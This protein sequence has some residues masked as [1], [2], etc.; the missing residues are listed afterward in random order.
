[1]VLRIRGSRLVGGLGNTVKE[2]VS[3]ESLYRRETVC[4]KERKRKERKGREGI[5]IV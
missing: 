4:G 2:T 1:M 5:S 3:T